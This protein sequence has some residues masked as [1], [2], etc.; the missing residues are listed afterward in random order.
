VQEICEL[1]I[2]DWSFE[3]EIMYKKKHN[4]VMRVN[5]CRKFTY[6]LQTLKSQCY[7]PCIIDLTKISLPVIT[8]SELWNRQELEFNTF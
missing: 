5:V 6:H 7:D 4:S 1:S 3:M 8:M 2:M